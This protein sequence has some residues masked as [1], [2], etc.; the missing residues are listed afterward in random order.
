[1]DILFSENLFFRKRIKN[2]LTAPSQ[3]PQIWIKIR[4]TNFAE[5]YKISFTCT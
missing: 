5:I 3:F 1:M 4:E 2:V